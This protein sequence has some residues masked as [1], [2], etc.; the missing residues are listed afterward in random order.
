MV[1]DGTLT[2]REFHGITPSGSVDVI[3]FGEEL[4]GQVS[5]MGAE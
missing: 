1:E 3:T 2:T 4:D 5:D